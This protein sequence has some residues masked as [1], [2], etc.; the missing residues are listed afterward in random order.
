MFDLIV[1][2]N[3]VHAGLYDNIHILW[4]KRNDL[5]HPSDIYD[6]TSIR[7]GG[8]ALNRGTGTIRHYFLLTEQYLAGEPNS[9]TYRNIVLVANLGCLCYFLGASGI[10]DSNG[11]ISRIDARPI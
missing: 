9:P 3:P 4:V 5:I 6:N 10:Y 8:I 2:V 11:P 1:E 7:R